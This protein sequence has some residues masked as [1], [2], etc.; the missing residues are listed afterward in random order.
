MRPRFSAVIVAIVALL[1]SPGWARAQTE[2]TESF[3]FPQVQDTTFGD[4]LFLGRFSW[5]H[6]SHGVKGTRVSTA[7]IVNMT[8]FSYRLVFAPSC[9]WEPP[10]LIDMYVN[11]V[12]VHQVQLPAPILCNTSPGPVTGT[13]TLPAPIPGRGA[14]ANEY[15]FRYQMRTHLFPLED[16]FV[17]VTID[18]NQSSVSIKGTTPVPPPPPPPDLHGDIMNLLTQ[19]LGRLDGIAGALAT[20]ASTLDARL[21]A[22]ES[23]LTGAIAANQALINQLSVQ[24]QALMTAHRVA[25]I[26]DALGSGHRSQ[27]LMIAPAIDEVSTLVGAAIATAQAG[28]LRSAAVINKATSEYNAGR[29]RLA[30][31]DFFG[32]YAL[33]ERAYQTLV[34]GNV[35][36]G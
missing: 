18:A 2:E 26:A 20:Q 7:N 4:N 19:V 13:V 5:F 21:T 30:A 25:R 35:G 27:D 3:P 29:A 12:F 31:G 10:P 11:D 24:L 34:T 28:G 16:L 9:V 1:A 32:A 14:H 22:I 33:F 36:L 17:F 15:E 23:A 6:N 8:E